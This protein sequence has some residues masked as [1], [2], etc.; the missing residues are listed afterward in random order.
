MKQ[1][2][3]NTV[4]ESIINEQKEEQARK[5]DMSNDKEKF[6]KL[7]VTAFVTADYGKGKD[8]RRKL[9]RYIDP[10]KDMIEDISEVEDIEPFIKKITDDGIIDWNMLQNNE[11][12]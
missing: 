5:Y 7:L 4:V 1:N 9:Y 12:V 3:F 10:L 8:W 6:L 2:K 11:N